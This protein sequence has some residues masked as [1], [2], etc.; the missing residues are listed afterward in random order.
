MNPITSDFI[1][2][3]PEYC[4]VTHI[5]NMLERVK[6][7]ERSAFLRYFTAISLVA[8]TA[9]VRSMVYPLSTTDAP[10][11]LFTVV[12]TA[13]AWFGGFGAGVVATLFSAVVALYRFMEPSY[14]FALDSRTQVVT[15]IVFLIE[16]VA[17][18]VFME[19]LLRV[20]EAARRS[21]ETNRELERRIL[22]ISEEERR[23]IGQDLHDGIGQHL[24]GTSM[25]AHRLSQR[26]SAEHSPLAGDAARISGL[27]NEAIASTRDVGKLLSPP[28]LTQEGLAVALE[29]LCSHIEQ[30]FGVSCQFEDQS[31]VIFRDSAVG[32]HLYRITQ[33]AISN[34]IK[35]G[36]ATELDVVLENS[37]ALTQITVRN[38]GKPFVE[39]PDTNPGLGLRIMRFRAK[40]IG[41][42]LQI[43]NSTDQQTTLVCS[44]PESPQ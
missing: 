37:D 8:A 22:E 23:R 19:H 26:L 11:M 44:L 4:H 20:V 31:T 21:E 16:G 30:L 29:D 5:A 10:L 40:M 12:V 13:A 39:P 17:I 36:N 24:T 32:T 7:S 38:N 33:E 2:T 42:K 18:S 3:R 9:G 28:L 14:R 41:A 43:R 15:L 25:M 27:L 35:H 6:V 34:A 1:L